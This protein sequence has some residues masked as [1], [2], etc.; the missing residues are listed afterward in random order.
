MRNVKITAAQII[1]LRSATQR[2]NGSYELTTA[3]G[4]TIRALVRMGVVAEGTRLLTVQGVS[5]RHSVC[6]V[7]VIASKGYATSVSEAVEMLAPFTLDAPEECDTDD[8]SSLPA[9]A[10][11]NGAQTDC[12]GFVECPCKRCI[13]RRVE[14]TG[15]HPD[16][17]RNNAP[18]CAV[19]RTEDIVTHRVTIIPPVDPDVI[20][21]GLAD[22]IVSDAAAELSD[23]IVSVMAE[24]PVV[25]VGPLPATPDMS[26]VPTSCYW[27]CGNPVTGAFC[28]Y[29]G[30]TEGVCDVHAH[31]VTSEVTP[32]PVVAETDAQEVSPLSGSVEMVRAIQAGAV[33]TACVIQ[34][35]PGMAG[36]SHY[37]SPA[38]AD[39]KREMRKFGQTKNDVTYMPFRSVAEILAFEY[40][41]IADGEAESDTPEWWTEILFNANVDDHFGVKIMPCLSIPAGRIG[42]SPLIITDNFYRKGFDQPSEERRAE[43][44]AEIAAHTCDE[45]DCLYCEV[46]A[47]ESAENDATDAGF[48]ETM[49]TKDYELSVIVDDSTGA[50]VSLGWVTLTMNSAQC[51]DWDRVA[52]EYGRV[53]GTGMP[54][55]GWA[56]IIT[57][58]DVA[59]QF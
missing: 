12:V 52:E 30:R 28:D 26:D 27:A 43:I 49:I 17:S 24:R 25:E 39:V 29:V 44:A 6:D 19:C 55:H 33:P 11:Q 58:H 3:K 38:C 53:H 21:A 7:S 35:T 13:A 41:D 16:H 15:M 1:A 46:N 4:Q 47:Q 45:S 23:M 59:D 20:R 18:Y 10:P 40:G 31:Q 5:I 51:M 34:N 54:R 22:P 32:L 14:T 37:H 50:T 36:V 9:N 42:D 8:E 57:V 48:M 56:S 2:D